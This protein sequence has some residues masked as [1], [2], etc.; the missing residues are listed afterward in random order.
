MNNDTKITTDGYK[1]YDSG[2]VLIHG[3]NSVLFEIKT[4]KIKVSFKKDE[5][6][7]GLP[8]DLAMIEDN[9][10]LEI[11]LVNFSGTTSGFVKPLEIGHLEGE[12]LYV[13]F[14][15]QTLGTTGARVLSYTWLTKAAE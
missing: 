3:D 12:I 10:C 11:T 9:T 15:V 7:E 13:Q 2:S 6:R 5:T 14:M 8:I 4:L 1:V